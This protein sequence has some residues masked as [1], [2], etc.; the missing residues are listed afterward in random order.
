MQHT[1]F[2]SRHNIRFNA[3]AVFPPVTVVTQ[4]YNWYRDIG[5]CN[6]PVYNPVVFHCVRV[7]GKI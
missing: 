1:P 5:V 3:L 7:V 4:K 6:I 2:Y